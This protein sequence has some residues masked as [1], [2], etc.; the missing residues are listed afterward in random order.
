[1]ALSRDRLLDACWGVDCLPESRTLER[2]IA[3]LRKKDGAGPGPSGVDRN[4]PG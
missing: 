3:T 2:H 1:M 4:H